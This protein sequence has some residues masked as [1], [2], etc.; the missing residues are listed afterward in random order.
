MAAAQ[1]FRTS[2][3]ISPTPADFAPLLFAGDWRTALS[4]VQELGYDAVEISVRDPLDP[5]VVGCDEAAHER[6]I[7]ISAIATGQ[8]F[9]SD[10]WAPVD[11]D[12]AV[13][14]SLR[15][16]MRRIV[17]MA[18]PWSALV[19][20][21][22]VR[23]VLEGTPEEQRSSYQRAVEFFNDLAEYA[24]SVGVRLVVEPINRYETNFIN[25]VAEALQF[26]DDVGAG[27]IGVLPDTFHMNIEEVSLEGALREA[28]QKMLH[29]QFTDSNRNAAGQGHIEFAPLAA[30]L[31]EVDY[32][33]YM[34][35]EILP[36][37]DDI[38]AARRAI[39]YFRS[40]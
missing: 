26:I 7:P 9:Y 11:P 17:D 40:L 13:R 15:R 5:D 35:A 21:G 20:I 28:G 25:T 19:V 29:V 4:T 18:A 38:T 10:G 2:V 27:N 39:E 14:E 32:S 1:P 23:G 37:P 36:E 8:S 31:R 24:S 33:G 6:G 12:P 3:A 16:R 22:G 30:V 34:S